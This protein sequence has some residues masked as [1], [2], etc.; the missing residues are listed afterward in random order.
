[1]LVYKL[2]HSSYPEEISLNSVKFEGDIIETLNK[3]TPILFACFEA[4]YA[5]TLATVQLHIRYINI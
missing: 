4:R 3:I 1:M 5:G 2:Q